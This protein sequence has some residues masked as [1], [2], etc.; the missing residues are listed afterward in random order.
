MKTTDYWTND[1]DGYL[2]R[3]RHLSHKAL[4]SF[5]FKALGNIKC[6]AGRADGFSIFAGVESVC[7]YGC[8]IG[9]NL[10]ALRGTGL[11]LYG[12]DLNPEAVEIANEMDGS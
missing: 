9:L 6:K 10:R 8:N 1:K 11:K 5:F 2:E 4:M 3:N 7:E 12:F